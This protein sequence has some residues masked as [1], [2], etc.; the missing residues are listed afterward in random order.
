MHSLRSKGKS[1]QIQ[2]ERMLLGENPQHLQTR[3][4]EANHERLRGLAYH[5]HQAGTRGRR[6]TRVVSQ[7]SADLMQGLTSTWEDHQDTVKRVSS[8]EQHRWWSDRRFWL[9]LFLSVQSMFTL[10]LRIHHNVSR[11]VHNDQYVL[12][13]F[14]P[15]TCIKLEWMKKNKCAAPQGLLCSLFVI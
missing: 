13:L 4:S 8:N 9:H 6:L 2:S 10:G 14:F 5:W 12:I 3:A 1:N 7:L 11:N 15:Q